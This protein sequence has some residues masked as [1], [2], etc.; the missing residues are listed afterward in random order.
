[1]GILKHLLRLVI[2]LAVVFVAGAFLL[3][4]HV[5]VHRSVEINAP[6]AAV[7]PHVNSMKA[8]ENWSPW[9]ARDPDV[10]LTYGG[11]DSG[12]GNRLEWQSDV[13]QVGSGSQEIITSEPDTLVV[14]ALDFGDMGRAEAQF[15]LVEAGGR[16]TVTWGFATDTGMNP[17]ARWMGVM[18]D[19]WVGGD[20]ERG[21]AN[22]KALIES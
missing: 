11:P 7:F 17:L 2:L 10:A 20:Y 4:R 5:D 22:L 21:L 9:L 16:T 14:T 18:M 15:S 8:T 1:M 3:P 12:V 19:G 13:P 6:A